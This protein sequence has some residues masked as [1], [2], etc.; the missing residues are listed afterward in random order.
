L[1][2]EGVETNQ[3]SYYTSEPI[4]ING[5]TYSTAGTYSQQFQNANG[6]DSIVN[7]NLI[8]L[9]TTFSV[10]NNNGTLSSPQSGTGYQWIDCNT[11]QPIPG[12]TTSTFVPTATGTYAVIVYGNTGSVTSQCISVTVSGIDERDERTFIIWPNPSSDEVNLSLGGQWTSAILQIRD[13]TG[14]LIHTQNVYTGQTAK[15][16]LSEL[17]LGVYEVIVFDGKS[18]STSKLIKS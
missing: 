3:I 13:M 8:F 5:Q 14:R 9:Q 17:P 6:C 4:T 15:L 10:T 18:K 7:I 12:A 2:I 16:R 11:N 1:T